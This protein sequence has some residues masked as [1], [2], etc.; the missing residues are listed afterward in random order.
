ML[1][2]EPEHALEAKLE[3][4]EGGGLAEGGVDLRHG[5]IHCGAAVRA[6]CR[7]RGTQAF[8]LTHG[9]RP[10]WHRQSLNAKQSI[11]NVTVI[12]TKSR[13]CLGN[14]DDL[15]TLVTAGLIPAIRVFT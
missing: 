8:S 2:S 4:I 13:C 7:D 11:G 5:A 1:R 9:T 6:I 12:V 3:I 15:R 10:V 14:G